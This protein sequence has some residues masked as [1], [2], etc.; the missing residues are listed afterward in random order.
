MTVERTKQPSGLTPEHVASAM[1]DFYPEAALAELRSEQ[2]QEHGIRSDV[3]KYHYD[4]QRQDRN[5]MLR[6]RL[7][8]KALAKVNNIGKWNFKTVLGGIELWERRK[9]LHIRKNGGESGASLLRNAATNLCQLCTDYYN[10]KKNQTTASRTPTWILEVTD[11]MQLRACDLEGHD[12]GSSEGG[13]LN[14]GISE[15]LVSSIEVSRS[16]PKPPTT[17]RRVLH[18]TYSSTSEVD[19]KPSGRALLAIEDGDVGERG[20]EDQGD[21]TADSWKYTYDWDDMRNCGKRMLPSGNWQICDR[22]EKDISSGFMKCFWKV[23]SGEDTSVSEVTIQEY[24]SNEAGMKKKPA[25]CMKKPA[26]C[27]KKPSAC[28][29][30]KKIRHREYSSAYHKAKTHALGNGY[31]KAQAKVRAQAAAKK[32]VAAIVKKK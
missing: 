9:E 6:Y 8:C 30:E 14:R 21:D 16:S 28:D 1:A 27:M 11:L 7:V 13:G 29:E 2:K 25:A 15:Q 22:I 12:G 31:T 17:K 10:C 18:F 3:I 5:A 23:S 32:H 24:E 4:G 19:P 26:T 20:D